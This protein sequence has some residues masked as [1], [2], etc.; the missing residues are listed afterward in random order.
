MRDGVLK[1]QWL[2]QTIEIFDE[3]TIVIGDAKRGDIEI[4]KNNTPKVYLTTSI[5]MRLL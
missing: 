1:F 5:L 2:E 3:E 4:L